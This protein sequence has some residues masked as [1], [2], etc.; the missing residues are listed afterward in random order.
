VSYDAMVFVVYTLL[1]F[2]SN[3]QRVKDFMKNKE[4]IPLALTVNALLWPGG[5]MAHRII[6]FKQTLLTNSKF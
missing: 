6:L 2:Y 3:K 1:S 4:L 5:L